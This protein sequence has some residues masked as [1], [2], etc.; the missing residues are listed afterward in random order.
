VVRGVLLAGIVALSLGG[1]ARPVGDFGR[2]QP[3]FTHDALLPAIGKGRADLAGEPVSRFNQTDAERDMH[4]RIWRFLV[5]PRTVDWS[6]DFAT[7]MRRTRL[8]P[9]LSTEFGVHRYY[10]F[11]QRTEFA[12]SPVRYHR[13]DEDIVDDLNTLP[14]TFAAVCAVIE[15]DRQRQV[16]LRAVGGSD[17]KLRGDTEARRIENQ[18]SIGWFAAALR[19]RAESYSYALDHLLVETPH[20]EGR[21][22]DRRLQLLAPY[23]RWAGMGEFCQTAAVSAGV[24]KGD[25]R[26]RVLMSPPSEG[27]Y[28]K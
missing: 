28:R 25:V 24:H 19:Y 2:A 13:I 12:S 22:V 27:P 1:C 23:V 10:R 7:E 15:V 4:N 3:S 16:A 8:G 17:G 18:V 14:S 21:L 20:E 11:L 26:G 9:D 6:Y 5:S